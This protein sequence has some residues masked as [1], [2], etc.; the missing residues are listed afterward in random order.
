MVFGICP[1]ILKFYA[2]FLILCYN[3]V[4]NCVMTVIKCYFNTLFGL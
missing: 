3:S 1:F 2:N 4:I